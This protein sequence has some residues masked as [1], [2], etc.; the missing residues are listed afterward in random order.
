M[1]ELA[2]TRQVKST[3]GRAASGGALAQEPPRATR[4]QPRSVRMDIMGGEMWLRAKYL[5]FAEQSGK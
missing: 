4:N 5:F 2:H 1:P 3:A